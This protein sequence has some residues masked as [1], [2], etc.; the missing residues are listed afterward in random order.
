M[1]KNWK[2]VK[3]KIEA[4]L[5]AILWD[6]PLEV[7]MS[8][9]GVFPS[10]AGSHGQYLSNLLFLV[11][12]TQA[13]SWWTVEPAMLQ[14]L[15][16]PELDLKA[17]KKFWVYTTVH[18]AHLMGDVDPPRCPAPWMNLPKLSELADEI[19]ESLDSVKTKEELSSLLWSWFAYMN[20]LNKWFFMI[21]PWE[22]GQKADPFGS[23]PAGIKPEWY[24]LFM[25]QALKKLPAHIG[26]LEGEFAGVAFFGLAFIVILLVPFLD[27][28]PRPGRARKLL[29]VFFGVGV[30]FFVAMTIWGL[31]E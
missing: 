11:A 29:N 23:A 24:F 8:R 18:M 14:A 27:R 6:E 3:A 28:G 4:E 10:G 31:V 12:D 5:E 2:D 7:K 17:C 21:F 19:V 25:F 16:D 15:D 20:R 1:A 26:P 22:L 13:M 9:L 30:V